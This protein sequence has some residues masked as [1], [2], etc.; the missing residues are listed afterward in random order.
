[1]FITQLV[2]L[3]HK[4]LADIAVTIISR[5]YSCIAAGKGY[6]LPSVSQGCVWKSF[7]QIRNSELV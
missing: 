5:A 1:M 2:K 3:D 6:K 7:H 4:K